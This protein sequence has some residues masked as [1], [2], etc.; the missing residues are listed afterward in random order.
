[1]KNGIARSVECPSKASKIVCATDAKE[2][3]EKISRKTIDEKPNDTA[4]GTPISIK[5]ITIA[6]SKKSSIILFPQQPWLYL[7]LQL[8]LQPHG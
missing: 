8:L 2:L 6:K 5:I 1:M 3:S 7:L 4:I